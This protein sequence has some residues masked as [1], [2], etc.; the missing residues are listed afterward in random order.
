MPGGRVGGTEEEEG[1]LVAAA[2][3]ARAGDQLRNLGPVSDRRLRRAVKA[4][5]HARVAD[6]EPRAVRVPRR[7]GVVAGRRGAR[8]HGLPRPFE[9]AG[10]V[11]RASPRWRRRRRRWQR[12]APARVRAITRARAAVLRVPVDAGPD[13]EEGKAAVVG[14]D[15]RV[16]ACAAG[17]TREVRVRAC[18]A[19][20]R[21][22]AAMRTTRGSSHQTST[23][24]STNAK[25]PLGL[26]ATACTQRELVSQV[27]RPQPPT[28]SATKRC[29]RPSSPSTTLPP[30][31]VWL[32]ATPK[33]CGNG[34]AGSSV[35]V[36][37][38]GP[39]HGAR[40]THTPPA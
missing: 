18:S 15:L 35:S 4:E 2:Q 28:I 36:E 34:C 5:E 29:A 38:F 25:G 7:R 19:R 20:A 30:Q 13:V 31:V 23:A 8:E 14:D 6:E 21:G 1:V 16:V 22:S 27:F 40:H 9:R 3:R 10:S 32:G 12:G 33:P 24:T 17:G 39:A 11:Q 37:Q 26:G